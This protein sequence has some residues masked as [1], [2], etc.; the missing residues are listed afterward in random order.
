MNENSNQ[1]ESHSHNTVSALENLEIDN[2]ISYKQALHVK[3]SRHSI[4]LK[5]EEDGFITPDEKVK[6]LIKELTGIKYLFNLKLLF[7]DLQNEFSNQVL[8]DSLFALADPAPFNL[9]YS[10]EELSR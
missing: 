4:L 7:E 8:I 2:S 10:K 3:T 5:L 1:S 6:E 9:Y